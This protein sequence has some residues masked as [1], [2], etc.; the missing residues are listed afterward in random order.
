MI[1]SALNL[2]IRI[3]NTNG[4]AET[5]WRYF[6][7]FW[8]EYTRVSRVFLPQKQSRRKDYIVL[9]LQLRITCF[10]YIGRRVDKDSEIVFAYS[11][12]KVC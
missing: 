3:F 8:Q 11:A 2:V 5:A 1:F 12:M 6:M 4:S 7:I 9:G 10:Y